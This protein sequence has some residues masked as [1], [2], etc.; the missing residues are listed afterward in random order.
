L[1]MMLVGSC[2]G[3]L[4]LR[5]YYSSRDR[6]RLRREG[7]SP[8]RRSSRRGRSTPAPPPPSAGPTQAT[9]PDQEPCSVSSPDQPLTG[10]ANGGVTP[11]RIWPPSP[12]AT[13]RPEQTREFPGYRVL[14]P[15]GKGGMGVVF[16]AMQLDLQRIVALKVIQAGDLA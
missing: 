12:P 5:G 10:N 15:L 3:G 6:R 2:L 7:L 13:S 1:A 14:A 9:K 8:A 11:T 4:V 16:R